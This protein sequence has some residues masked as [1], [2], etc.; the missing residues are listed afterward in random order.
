MKTITESSTGARRATLPQL[1][2]TNGPRR[3]INAFTCVQG[4]IIAGGIYLLTFDRPDSSANVFD[5]NTLEEL[6]RHLAFVERHPELRGM[7]LTSSKPAIFIAGAD[8]HEMAGELLAKTGAAANEGSLA[9]LHELIDLGQ[10]AFSR[11][12]ALPIPTVAAIHG[13]CV[14]GGYEVALACDYRIAS[15]DKATRIG[16][17]ETQLGILPAWGG[18]TRLPRL[19]GMPKALDVILGGKVLAA[20]QALKLGLVDRVVP[21]EY[22]LDEAMKAA[23]DPNSNLKARVLPF[24]AKATRYG[25]VAKAISAWVQPRVMKKTHGHY[26]AIPRALKMITEGISLS[27]EESLRLE[28]EAVME[29]AQ[30][31][32]ARNL[33]RLF[34]LQEHAKKFSPDVRH[35]KTPPV[36]NAAVIGAGVMG[37]GIAQ[38]LSTRQLRVILRDVNAAQ[39]AKGMATIKELYA[40]AEKRRVFDHATARAGV[41]RITPVAGEIS[42]RGVDV[43]I[44]AAVERMDLKQAIFKQLAEQTGPDTVLATN[45]SALSISAIAEATGA[46]GRVVGLH[47]FNP[48]HKMQL[49]EVIAGLQTDNDI[50]R[51]AVRFVQQIGKLPV[52]VQDRPG[53]LVNRILMPY[54]LEAGHLWEAGAT[55]RDLDEAMLEFGMPMGPMR[56]IDEVGVDVA[57]HVAGTLTEA[58]PRRMVVPGVL[59]KMLKAGLLGRKSGKGFYI[60]A[61]K[62]ARV[63]DELHPLRLSSGP[64]AYSREALQERMVL[65]M[66]N[67]AARCL[68]EDVVATPEDVDFGMILGTGFAPFRGGPLRYGDFTGAQTLVDAMNR[69]VDRGMAAN[70]GTFYGKG[71]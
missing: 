25:F 22:L 34:F 46:P 9:T 43:V 16:L 50:L 6:N 67:E 66:V 4:E 30:T 12:A 51:R 21:A 32:A 29:L 33:L 65:L 68:E 57:A 61:G 18:S 63:N 13:A 49:V 41:D 26:P 10:R 59:A 31:E 53:F 40:K 19:I 2:R 11:L 23:G 24:Q 44:E 42:L 5:R 58:F 36:T 52:L 71:L 14:G 54:L 38:W 62:S 17:P 69:W 39:L 56:L 27:V 15:H 8:L 1:P 47:F 70:G 35:V 60:H 3:T 20:K 28:S 7:V 37:A 55:V 64:G 45:T 48:V